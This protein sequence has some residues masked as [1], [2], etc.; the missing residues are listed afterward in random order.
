M[1]FR[2]VKA[3]RVGGFVAGLL[4]GGGCSSMSPRWS[5]GSEIN[6]V[7]VAQQTAWNN[8]D[9][10]AFMESYWRSGDLSFSS[11]GRVTRGWDE[12][13]A[14]YRK[15]YPTR[16]AMGQL[17]FSDLEVTRL[18]NDAALVLGRWQLDR[19]DPIGGAFTLVLRKDSGHWVIV[20]DHTSRDQP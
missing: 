16:D 18:A 11:G 15:R 14:G 13:L 9:I 5:D 12:T 7:L 6:S 1:V 17:S 4:V 10:E 19:Q 2:T 20:H 8:G 3:L